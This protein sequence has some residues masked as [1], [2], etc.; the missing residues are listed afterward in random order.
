MHSVPIAAA[1]RTDAD[2][3]AVASLEEPTRRRIYDCVREQAGPVSREEV[4]AE[5]DVPLRTAAFHLDRLADLG[6]LLVSFA[7]RTGRSGPGAGR[8]AKLYQ[9]SAREVSVCLPQRQ[10]D[11]A[12]R[13]LAAAVTE[14]QESGEPPRQVLDRR[15]HEFGQG[16]ARE[17]SGHEPAPGPGQEPGLA[18]GDEPRDESGDEPVQSD[19]G[20]LVRLLEAHGFEPH[21]VGGDIIL[22]NCPFHALTQEHAELVCGMSLRLLEGVLDGLGGT[23]VHARLD[24]GDSRC[25]V[26]LELSGRG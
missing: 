21:F 22:R 7:R 14:A 12:G 26:R 1:G 6:L 9:R 4:A 20:A 23:G 13:L 11:L 15:A 10:Y 5:L 2:V 16:M 18:S 3:A 19:Q 8:P 25:C 24:P 17:L